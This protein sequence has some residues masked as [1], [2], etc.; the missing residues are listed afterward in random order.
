MEQKNTL[1][2]IPARYASTRFPGKPLALINNKPM[3]QWVFENASATGF[4]TVVATDDARIA[5]AVEAFGGNVVMTRSDHPS[6]TDRC[7]EAAEKWSLENNITID[8]VINVQ[9]DEPFIKAEQIL[10]LAD[11]F[12]S[13]DTD[14]ATL[15]RKFD[16]SQGFEPLSDP[17]KVKVIFNE[18]GRGI[19]FSRSVIPYVRGLET[20]G[21]FKSRD[22]YHHIG[23]YAYRF[24]VLK[25]IIALPPSSLELAESLEQLRW[26][27]NEYVIK[28][29]ETNHAS[30]GV[31]TPEDLEQIQKATI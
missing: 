28:V 21:W 15:A 2:V 13:P 12:N 4:E 30:V 23:M 24:D 7:F 6:G 1:I 20:E 5:N 31:D 27:E 10:A 17:N 22:F 9:G 16:P 25:Q 29:K 3:I 19:Y 11:A 14:I 8:L 18:K 26:L